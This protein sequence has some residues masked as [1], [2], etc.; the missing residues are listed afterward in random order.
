MADRTPAEL[1]AA[2]DR[3][4][5]A[6]RESI[7]VLLQRPAEAM[8]MAAEVT[9]AY[10]GMS[11]ATRASTVAYVTTPERPNANAF[12]V[13]YD[14]AAEHLAGF[15]GHDGRPA[16]ISI[17]GPRR[18]EAWILLTV[19]TDYIIKL[20]TE[21]AGAKSFL[22][23]AFAGVAPAIVPTIAPALGRVWKKTVKP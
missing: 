15:T 2:L 1:S 19:P 18:A 12:A 13:A 14:V 9:T 21:N 22:P 16:S 6:T 17:E 3:L 20:E 4:L 5:D 10:V 11:G 7:P 23:D 8:Q